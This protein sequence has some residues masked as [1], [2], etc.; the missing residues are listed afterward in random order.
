ML[1]CCLL[2]SSVPQAAQIAAPQTEHEP[3]RVRALL[4]EAWA[5]EKYSRSNQ[6]SLLAAALY[7]E[8]ARF[9]SAE[10][11]FRAALIHL[12][13]S[14][15]NRNLIHAKSFLHYAH[16][17]G[18]PFAERYLS[19]VSEVA[20]KVPECLTQAEAYRSLQKLD[21]N[22]H[23][24]HLSKER[25]QIANLVARLAP[26]YG[27]VPELALAVAAAESN[28][29]PKALSP[30][31]ATGVMQLIPAT[32]E[33]F[34]VQDIWDIEQNIRGGLAYLRWLM[35]RFA[36]NT[37]LAVAAYNAGEGN[38]DRYQGVPPFYETRSYVFRVLNNSRALQSNPERKDD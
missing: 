16:E 38:V 28:F 10:G 5:L 14:A 36:N 21:F 3:P 22:A 32:A 1:G 25:R 30:K 37:E 34:G 24:G 35:K 27:I 29:N 26:E 4:E 23:L 19:E 11:H 31:N 2:F 13:G 8:A 17:L 12:R 20:I 9:G 33:R 7:C 18:H 15:A 6:Y